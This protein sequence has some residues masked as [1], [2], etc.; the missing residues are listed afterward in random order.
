MG[1]AQAIMNSCSRVLLFATCAVVCGCSGYG[2]SEHFEVVN[3]GTLVRYQIHDW[4][5]EETTGPSVGVYRPPVYGFEQ[6]GQTYAI[7]PV[8]IRHGVRTVGPPIAPVWPVPQE[9]GHSMVLSVRHCNG[10]HDAVTPAAV[11]LDVES[12]PEVRLEKTASDT[13]GTVFSAR[14]PVSESLER[15]VLAPVSSDGSSRRVTFARR[16]DRIYSPVFSFNAPEP[17]P[18]FRRYPE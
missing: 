6:S 9:Q 12:T 16:R 5:E 11:R 18:L 10:G 1:P 2:T 14:L 8:F 4:Y 13:V 3:D 17:K 7:Y 15:F